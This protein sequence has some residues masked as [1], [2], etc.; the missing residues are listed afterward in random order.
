MRKTLNRESGRSA[1]PA[2]LLV[3]VTVA[4]AVL[5]ALAVGGTET[6]RQDN[7]RQDTAMPVLP[8]VFAP[9]PG[10]QAL[11]PIAPDAVQATD[12]VATF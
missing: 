7:P 12:Y 8:D 9:A 4:T 1:D 2:W 6:L 10:A 3:V 5:A 11:P